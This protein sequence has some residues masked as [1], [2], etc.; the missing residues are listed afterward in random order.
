MDC[1][2]YLISH[3]PIPF[4]CAVS[5]RDSRLLCPCL[6]IYLL[7]AKD[8]KVR[9]ARVCMTVAGLVLQGITGD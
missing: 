9:R 7:R 5:V 4:S 8:P 6:Y 1:L 3:L 2:A